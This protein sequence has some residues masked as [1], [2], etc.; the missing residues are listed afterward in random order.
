MDLPPELAK[1]LENAEKISDLIDVIADIVE[2]YDFG[3][4]SD[5][6]R[7]IQDLEKKSVD[8]V[9]DYQDGSEFEK[10]TDEIIKRR[11]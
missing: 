11:S 2:V 10:E 9:F 3:I 7:R 1:R 4:L 5:F 8:E 6:E